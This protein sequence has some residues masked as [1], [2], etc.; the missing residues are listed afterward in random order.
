[1]LYHPTAHEVA[2]ALHRLSSDRPVT[3][4]FDR[5][6][7]SPKLFK[8]LLT[9]GFHILTYRKGRSARLT[10]SAFS[11]HEAVLDGRRVRY[12]LADRGIYIQY[13]PRHARHRLHLRQVT[14]LG[15]DG[16]Q[17]QVVTSRRDLSAIEVA[18]LMFA[19]WRQE[20]FFKYLREEYALDALVDYG[21]EPADATRDVPRSANNSTRSC[22]RPTPSSTCLPPHMVS[23]PS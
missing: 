2:G 12:R 1:M 3:V 22:A 23:R 16:H 21:V 4:V 6:G 19:R 17:T 9:R 10:D 11:H 18:Y 15:D 8:E 5:G 14:R 7:W 20:N 13:G